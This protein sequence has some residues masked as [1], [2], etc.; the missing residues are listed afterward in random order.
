MMNQAAAAR[1]N[2]GPNVPPK[3]D[4]AMAL[5]YYLEARSAGISDAET[6]IAG[7]ETWMKQ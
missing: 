7:L 4:P 5:K 6:A 1:V 2:S 3:P